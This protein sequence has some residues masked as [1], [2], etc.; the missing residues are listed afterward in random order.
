M[1]LP[2]KHPLGWGWR[3]GPAVPH[4]P[5]TVQLCAFEGQVIVKG[6]L[7]VSF[8]DIYSMSKVLFCHFGL[9]SSEGK[10]MRDS[11]RETE[12]EQARGTKMACH[13]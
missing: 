10:R 3:G 12:R 2:R 4:G 1:G 8:C 11:E 13:H 5:G 7:P 6:I 9:H